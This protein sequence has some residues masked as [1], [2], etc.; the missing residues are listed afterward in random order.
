MASY[1]DHIASVLGGNKGAFAHLTGL[2]GD[3]ARAVARSRLGEPALA[4][5]AVQEAFLAAYLNLAS[6]KDPN[7]FPGWFRTILLRCCEHQ[8]REREHALPSRYADPDTVP[9]GH[10]DDPYRVCTWHLDQDMVREILLALPEASREACIQRFVYGQPYKDI[11]RT[12]GLPLGTIKRRLHEARNRIIAAF[13]Q[14]RGKVLRLGYM[15]VSDHLAAMVAHSLQPEGARELLLT[16]FLSWTSLTQ[17][18]HRGHLDAAF[19]MA[20]LAMALFNDGLRLRYVMDGHH[21]GSAV[22]LRQEGPHGELGDGA[23][24]ALPHAL[25]THRLLLRRILDRVPQGPGAGQDLS[26]RYISPSYVGSSMARREID[27]FLCSEPW[28]TASVLRG[29]GRILAYSDELLPGH[30]CCILVVRDAFA[31][32]QPELLHRVLVSLHKAGEFIQSRPGEAARVQA[33]YTGVDRGVA[34]HILRG[35]HVSFTDLTPDRGRAGQVMQAAL[36]AG[37]L[38]APCDLGTFVDTGFF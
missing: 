29:Q 27:G 6:L 11:A 10:R 37:M 28:N 31:R 5:D 12:L 33:R 35:G 32:E 30:I 20:P 8:R 38:A 21:D 15:P 34:E 16:R 18:L 14:R 25:S 23:V 19:V 22:T 24:V 4:E 26:T 1:V 2:F 7:A 13:D 36:G 9:A 17:S 3:M